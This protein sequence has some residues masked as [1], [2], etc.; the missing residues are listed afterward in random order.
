MMKLKACPRC[1]GDLNRVS[2]PGDTYFSCLQCGY[3]TYCWPPV[4]APCEAVAAE[5]SRALPG[6]RRR[7]GE[8]TAEPARRSPSRVIRS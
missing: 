4:A 3:V 6:G 8:S 1:H 7:R 5:K 2:E